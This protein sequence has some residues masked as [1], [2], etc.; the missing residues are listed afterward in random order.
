MS[1]VFLIKII[2]KEYGAHLYLFGKL[3]ECKIE[4]NKWYQ[5]NSGLEV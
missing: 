5:F 4:Y 2:I 1:F 3:N